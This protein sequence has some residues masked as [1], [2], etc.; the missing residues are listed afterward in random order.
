MTG[1]YT[2]I[3]RL[4]RGFAPIEN[5]LLAV[6]ALVR[7]GGGN[8]R[9]GSRQAAGYRENPALRVRGGPACL[10]GEIMPTVLGDEIDVLAVIPAVEQGLEDMFLELTARPEEEGPE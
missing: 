7:S 4:S 10:C 1:K 5:A 6:L 2:S 9:R 3:L 8:Y